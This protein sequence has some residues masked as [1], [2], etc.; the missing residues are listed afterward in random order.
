MCV[1]TAAGKLSS[2]CASPAA[3]STQPWTH[4][5]FHNKFGHSDLLSSS[6]DSLPVV[7]SSAVGRPFKP[8]GGPKVRTSTAA[9]VDS[10]VR[11]CMDHDIASWTVCSECPV[12]PTDGK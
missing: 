1:S 12:L 7:H 11:S 4:S 9:A 10:P 8:V 5:L 6:A 3:K 2:E